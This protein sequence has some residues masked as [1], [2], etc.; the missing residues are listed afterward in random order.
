VTARLTRA[1]DRLAA[2]LLARLLELHPAAQ[3]AFVAE[4][5]REFGVLAEP[6]ETP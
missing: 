1:V 2:T 4:V 3:K 6:D 5:R